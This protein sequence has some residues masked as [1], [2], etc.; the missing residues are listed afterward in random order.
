MRKT[1]VVSLL[2]VA[3]PAGCGRESP[4]PTQ[5]EPAQASQATVVKTTA[6]S[7]FDPEGEP[8]IREMS[9]GT[10]TV[11]FNV[12]PPSYAEDEEAKY[13]DFDKEME[14]AVGE[15]VDREDRELFL[16]RNPQSDTAEKLKAFLEGYRKSG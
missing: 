10:L 16:I 11:I 5:K 13:A 4:E 3:A 1:V 7:G 2:L 14:R 9:D 15:P 8:E 12:M 6:V